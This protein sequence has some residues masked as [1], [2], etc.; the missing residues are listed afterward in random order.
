[1]LC[2]PTGERSECQTK[3]QDITEARALT[4][5]VHMAD[6]LVPRELISD[7]IRLYFWGPSRAMLNGL[8]VSRE[9]ALNLGTGRWVRWWVIVG[10]A[11]NGGE[12]ISQAGTRPWCVTSGFFFWRKEINGCQGR[13]NEMP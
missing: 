11:M 7:G 9:R 12:D 4:P 10:G 3:A 6:I 1:M 2:L 13:R 5:R 8:R